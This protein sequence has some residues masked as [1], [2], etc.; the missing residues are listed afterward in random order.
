M[1]DMVFQGSHSRNSKDWELVDY[2]G[3]LGFRSKG[4]GMLGRFRRIVGFLNGSGGLSRAQILEKLLMVDESYR[5]DD[6]TYAL[7]R[8]Q[9]AGIVS[10]QGFGRGAV[11]SLTNNGS[12]MIKRVKPIIR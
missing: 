3:R 9:S 12:R 7:Q 8:M 5:E 4:E 11:W 6:V 1:P 2:A 10:L